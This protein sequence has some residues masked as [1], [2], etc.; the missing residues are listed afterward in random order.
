MYGVISFD[1]L[2]AP[3]LGHIEHSEILALGISA[4]SE[5]LATASPPL[6]L[7]PDIMEKMIDAEVYPSESL[8]KHRISQIPGFPI[9]AKDLVRMVNTIIQRGICA[10]TIE[11]KV[12]VDW[13]TKNLN[14]P[15]QGLDT[16]RKEDL[17][18]LYEEISKSS[19][20]S[21]EAYSVLYY[22]LKG[23]NFSRQITFNG[24]AT[25]IFPETTEPLPLAINKHFDVF[26]DYFDFLRKCDGSALFSNATNEGQLKLA[27]F[28]GALCLANVCGNKD[29]VYLWDNFALG[30]EFYCSLKNNESGPGMRFGSTVYEAIIHILVYR[31]KSDINIFAKTAGGTEARTDGNFTAYRTHLTSS[32]RG[33][34]LMFWRDDDGAIEFSNVGNKFELKIAALS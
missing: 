19:Y 8:Y 7:E 25:D 10:S 24:I 14:P 27:F 9:D 13:A 18:A 34:R 30:G 3:A 12:E 2:L 16:Q 22:C 17:E 1:I 28:V 15:F 4:M 21:G 26:Y 33:L 20:I 11:P 5:H 29:H 32:G 31:P 23:V 6:Y